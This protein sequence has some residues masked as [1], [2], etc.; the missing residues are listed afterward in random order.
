MSRLAAAMAAA[1]LLPGAAVADELAD[2]GPD[3][4]SDPYEGNTA[5]TTGRVTGFR[6]L[7]GAPDAL[8]AALA[9]STP[10]AGRG[11]L[12]LVNDRLSWAEVAVNGQVL[13]VMG[14]QS[15][16][17]IHDVPAG[18]YA[19]TLT[20]PTG[21]VLPATA[22]TVAPERPA[23]PDLPSLPQTPPSETP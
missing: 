11:D 15:R 9:P 13:G 5:L 21:Y 16:A 4:R 22:T 3:L 8:A 1:L 10:A 18:D 2:R 19:Y 14:P 23:T 17:R 7:Y 6:T 12:P 20:Y